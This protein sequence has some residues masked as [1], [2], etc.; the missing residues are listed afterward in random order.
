MSRKAFTLIELLV[1]IAI[2]GI[3]I[4]LLLPAV[5]KVRE[6]ANR[7][8]CDNNLKQVA[9]AAH[10]FHDNHDRF[11]PAFNAIANPNSW[12][13]KVEAGKTYSLFMSLMPYFEQDNLRRNL[14]DD[15]NTL[16]GTPPSYNNGDEYANNHGANAVGAQV[17][18]I[19]IC[20]SSPVTE[21]PVCVYAGSNYFGM[22]SYGGIAGT[23]VAPAK[24]PNQHDDYKKANGMFY[25]NSRTKIADI[26][27]GTSNT[28]MFG[29]RVQD[30]SELDGTG[31]SKCLGGWC[32]LN[33]KY[34]MEDHTLSTAF[35]INTDYKTVTSD[36]FNDKY[37]IIG[38]KHSGGANVACADGSVHFLRESIDFKVYQALSTINL[39]AVEPPVSLDQ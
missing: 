9:L 37:N 20:P 11:P 13:P 25:M 29:E 1:V 35:P 39:G 23:T 12:P 24:N 16:E 36:P 14:I 8:K 28:L 27:D 33:F 4:A 18:Q 32:W 5:Q 3:L 2:I 38:S 30:P 19:L 21:H 15:S 7:A 26:T 34:P 22:N 31:Q 6:A 10:G 17:V